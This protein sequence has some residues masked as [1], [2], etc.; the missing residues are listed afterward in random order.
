MEK[1][2]RGQ[3]RGCPD[4]WTESGGED[5]IVRELSAFGNLN[6]KICWNNPMWEM[7][8]AK[9]F[10]EKNLKK[11]SGCTLYGTVTES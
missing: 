10:K 7:L 4:V 1:L 9:I 6:R 8:A 5:I 3:R 11:R 2:K